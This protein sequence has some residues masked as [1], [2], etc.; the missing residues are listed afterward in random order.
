MLC[1]ARSQASTRPTSSLSGTGMWRPLPSPPRQ[2][3]LALL[4]E[5][6]TLMSLFGTFRIKEKR[7]TWDEHRHEHLM[8]LWSLESHSL[9]TL[10]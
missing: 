10:Q 8:T 7:W 5:A 4:V 3:P 2:H 9:D 6:R 1:R